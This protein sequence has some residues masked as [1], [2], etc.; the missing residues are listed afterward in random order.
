MELETALLKPAKL[1]A[2]S[3]LY[4]TVALDAARQASGS[5]RQ[6]SLTKLSTAR[7]TRYSQS[8]QDSCGLHPTKNTG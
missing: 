2:I 1:T 4:Q 5:L 6:L 7:G 8:G 3:S